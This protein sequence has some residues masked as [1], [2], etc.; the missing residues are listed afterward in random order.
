MVD[1]EADALAVIFA[2]FPG[3]RLIIADVRHT[4]PC[5]STCGRRVAPDSDGRPRLCYVCTCEEVGAS[6]YDLAVCRAHRISLKVWRT[7]ES[8]ADL[9]SITYRTWRERTGK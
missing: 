6:A 4:W 1:V 9:P 8:E 2:V 5:C 3:S 7:Y